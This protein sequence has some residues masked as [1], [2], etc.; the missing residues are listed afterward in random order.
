M[1]TLEDFYDSWDDQNYDLVIFDEFKG[2]KTI[3]F[4]NSWADGQ[5]ISVRKK[6]KQG[7]KTVNLPFIV[8]SNWTFLENYKKAAEKSMVSID[9]LETR[10]EVVQFFT[11]VRSPEER[12]RNYMDSGT[13]RIDLENIKFHIATRP[14]NQLEISQVP[15]SQ[16]LSSQV[17]VVP[18]PDESDTDSN[19][20]F[21]LTPSYHSADSDNELFF[22]VVHNPDELD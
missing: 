22:N 21:P 1:P 14:I 16:L 18:A 3:Q 2:Q 17:P 11:D 19:Y 6:G 9:T 13:W 7:I 15:N 10:F 12:E 8:A 20:T 4:M 5:I